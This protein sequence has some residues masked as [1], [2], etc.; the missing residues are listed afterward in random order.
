[1]VRRG[2]DLVGERGSAS[3][4]FGDDLLC[5]LVPDERLGVVVPVVG[6]FVDGVDEVVNA[7]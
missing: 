5:G 7:S 2:F 1:V 4:D 3:T 6:P